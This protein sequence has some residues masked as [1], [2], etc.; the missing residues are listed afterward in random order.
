MEGVMQETGLARTFLPLMEDGRAG[1][2]NTLFVIVFVR[3]AAAFV[4]ALLCHFGPL[5]IQR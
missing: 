1:V 2:V 5:A 3:L 4:D